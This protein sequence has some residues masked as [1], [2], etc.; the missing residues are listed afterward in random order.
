MVYKAN[1][2]IVFRVV[3]K[4]KFKQRELNLN[5]K[6]IEDVRVNI[7]EKRSEK[8]M[9]TASTYS[10]LVH[11]VISCLHTVYHLQKMDAVSF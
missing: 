5:F 4:Q 11:H 9:K 6:Y 8:N 2:W 3:P 1:E 7:N 10:R